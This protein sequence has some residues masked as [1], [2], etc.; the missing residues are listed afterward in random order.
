MSVD[1]KTVVGTPAAVLVEM[2]KAGFR[3]DIAGSASTI[4]A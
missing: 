2:L 3:R 1:R 4:A